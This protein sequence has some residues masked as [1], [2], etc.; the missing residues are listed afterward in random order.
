MPHGLVHL[1]IAVTSAQKC[2]H[3][4]TNLYKLWS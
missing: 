3:W 1:T 2:T 4:N